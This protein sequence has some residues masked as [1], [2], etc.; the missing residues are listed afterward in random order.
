MNSILA[1][2]IIAIGIRLVGS[3]IIKTIFSSMYKNHRILQANKVRYLQ[4]KIPKSVT[5]K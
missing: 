3:L 5:T 4:I 2:I 1:I